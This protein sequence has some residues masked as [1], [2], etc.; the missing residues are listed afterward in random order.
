VLREVEVGSQCRGDCDVESRVVG[1]SWEIVVL[2]KLRWKGERIGEEL[3]IQMVPDELETMLQVIVYGQLEQSG[4]LAFVERSDSFEIEDRLHVSLHS[5]PHPTII[6]I[7]S[8]HRARPV[9]LQP[10]FV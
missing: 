1:G 4:P 5:F 6:P 2:G 9:P 10:P 8:Q 7:P 3:W